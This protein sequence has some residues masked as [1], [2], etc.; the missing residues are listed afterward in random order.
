VGSKIEMSELGIQLDQ[1]EGFLYF[2]VNAAEETTPSQITFFSR[3]QS[4]LGRIQSFDPRQDL[5]PPTVK[6]FVDATVIDLGSEGVEAQSP[7]QKESEDELRLQVQEKIYENSRITWA[8][9]RTMTHSTNRVHLGKC[10]VGDR[11]VLIC[12]YEWDSA[13]PEPDYAS[14]PLA[15]IA[16]SIHPL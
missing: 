9:P 7:F 4:L 12:V 1:V 3:E 2:N 8:S 5:W 14:G 10:D 13:S 6:S 11:A 16:D 15:V